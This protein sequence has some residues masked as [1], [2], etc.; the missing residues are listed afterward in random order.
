M[1]TGGTVGMSSM[2]PSTHGAF[3]RKQV[4]KESDKAMRAQKVKIRM[5]R[6][7]RQLVVC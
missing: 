2:P 4:I 1:C 3:A 5:N 7:R 6:A